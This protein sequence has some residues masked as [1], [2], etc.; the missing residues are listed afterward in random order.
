MADRSQDRTDSPQERSRPEIINGSRRK[1]IAR[2]SGTTIIQVNQLLK[3]FGMMRKMMRSKGK[4]RKMMKQ[5]GGG[6][7]GAG[8]PGGGMPGGLPRI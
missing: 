8:G 2:G 1:R 7:P 4:M 5:F 6:L 3:Q